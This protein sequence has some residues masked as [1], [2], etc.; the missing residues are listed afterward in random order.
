MRIR[1][2]MA[3]IIIN[4]YCNQSCDYCF[5]WKNM[6]DNS[7]KKEMTLKT[8]LFCLKHLHTIHDDRVRILW[9]E[10]LLHSKIKEIFQISTKGGFYM[11]IFSNLKIPRSK[12]ENILDLW[13]DYDYFRL[14]FNLNLNDESFYKSVELNMI[15]DSLFFLTQKWCDRV[16]SYNIYE[17]SYKYDFVFAVAA[18]YNIKTVILK[19]TNTVIGD[20]EIIDTNS[21]QYGEYIYEIVQKYSKDFSIGFSCWLSS[22]IFT[23][24]QEEFLRDVAG[25]KF[26]YGCENNGWKYDIN[27]DGT[28][29]RCYPLQSLYN[30]KWLDISNDLFQNSSLIQV[31]KYIESFVPRNKGLVEDENCLGNQMN[32]LGNL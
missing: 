17:Y 18:R 30:D 29:Y 28:V 21:K 9:G 31:R 25:I 13:D 10:P 8:F 2:E 6:Q 22:K 11:T 15:Y 26:W 16:I 27:T 23:Q 19:V 32:R 5:A 7:L 24:K 4:N 1:L 14:K 12:W 20:D 3:N